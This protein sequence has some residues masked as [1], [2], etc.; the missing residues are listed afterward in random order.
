MHIFKLISTKARTKKLLKALEKN[1]QKGNEIT[2]QTHQINGLQVTVTNDF[3]EEYLNAGIKMA[4]A[5]RNDVSYIMFSQSISDEQ[6]PELQTCTS[7]H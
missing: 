4:F 6:Q 2:A 7:E 5:G 3:H 1:I